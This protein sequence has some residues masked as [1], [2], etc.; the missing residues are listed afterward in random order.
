MPVDG[1]EPATW[2]ATREDVFRHREIGKDG[3]LLVHGDDPEPVRVL[4]AAD[5]L[6]LTLDEEPAVVGLDDTRQDLHERR[7]AGAVLADERVHR[8]GLDRE[9]DVVQGLH[10]AVALRNL[11]ELDERGHRGYAAVTPPSTLR[12]LP[13]DFAARGPARKAIASATSSG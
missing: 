11:D 1:V 5:S 2:V 8:P 13:V 12:T 6:G 9:A 4:R 3:R 10:T 7:L